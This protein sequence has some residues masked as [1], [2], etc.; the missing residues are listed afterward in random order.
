MRKSILMALALSLV[1]AVGGVWAESM[2]DRMHRAHMA[3]KKDAHAMGEHDE[4][5][6]PGL[7]GKDTTPTEVSDL[8]A[9]FTQHKA[10]SRTVDNLPDGIRTVTETDDAALRSKLLSHVV[11]M[12]ARFQNGRDPEVVI[13]SPTLTALFKHAD[14]I[15]T[16]I[17]M[18]ATGV[19]VIQTSTDANV[20]ALL[21]A[22][23]AEVSDMSARGMQAVHERMQADH[24]KR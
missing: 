16:R 12:L 17:E 23:A 22:H 4:V 8:K 15:A 11:L 21:Q 19:V 3:G 9:L 24:H 2:H 6:M 14:V 1:T 5:N 10:L 20:V 7:N 13:Q 18:S